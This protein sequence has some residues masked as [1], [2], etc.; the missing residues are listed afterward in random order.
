MEL[1]LKL[2]PRD[3][4]TSFKQLAER[5]I[6]VAGSWAINDATKDVHQHMQDRMDTIFDKPTRFAKNSMTIKGATPRTLEAVIQERPSV[7]RRHFLKV[8]QTGGDRPA[9]GIEKLLKATV[10]YDGNFAAVI[11]ANGAKLDAFGNWSR[12]E[13]NQ[14]MSQLKAGR[15]VGFNSNETDDSKKRSR[16]RNRARYFIPAKGNSLTP[17]VYKR[18]TKGKVS[19]ILHFTTAMPTYTPRLHFFEEAEGQF[20]RRLPAHL[21]RTFEKMAVRRGILPPL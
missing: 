20:M 8:Q 18:T 13:R 3:L 4:N 11:P 2:D 15:E 7:G 19:K 21:Q 5:D 14:V 10:D 16:A 9:T 12:G 1:S 6:R 17:G